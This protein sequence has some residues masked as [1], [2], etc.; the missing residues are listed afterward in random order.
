MKKE[1]LNRQLEEL[2]NELRKDNKIIKEIDFH[3]DID[4]DSSDKYYMDSKKGCIKFLC[5]NPYHIKYNDYIVLDGKLQIEGES[6]KLISQTNKFYQDEIKRG[7]ILIDKQLDYNKYNIINCII[8]ASNNNLCQLIF[9]N[10]EY[11]SLLRDIQDN[12]LL[13]KSEVIKDSRYEKTT[14]Y[15][16]TLGN[17]IV[18]VTK[19]IGGKYKD[20]TNVYI[21]SKTQKYNITYDIINRK[22]T[23]NKVQVVLED[24]NFNIQGISLAN[25]KNSITNIKEISY[26]ERKGYIYL[27][28]IEG[29]P[30]KAR[31]FMLYS[32]KGIMEYW[33]HQSDKWIKISN[34]SNISN[35]DKLSIRIAMENEDKVYSIMIADDGRAN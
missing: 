3:S 21:P 31:V 29:L 26:G 32:G 14:F 8:D 9:G 16:C 25:I 10:N 15:L 23:I 24:F 19:N 17:K 5:G 20:K 11:C 7:Q 27:K 12:K 33:E 2:K 35:F 30:N 6:I 4:V 18:T 13:S 28:P 34:Q 1:I 22:L